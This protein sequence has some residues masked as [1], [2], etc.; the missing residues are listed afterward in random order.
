MC[1]LVLGVKEHDE[2]G[3]ATCAFDAHSRPVHVL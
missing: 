1:W 3:F 2:E